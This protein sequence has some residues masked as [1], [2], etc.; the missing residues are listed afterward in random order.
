MLGVC[1]PELADLS[2]NLADIGLHV[3]AIVQN[4]VRFGPT[5]TEHRPGLGQIRPTSTECGKIWANIGLHSQKLSPRSLIEH[6]SAWLSPR[7]TAIRSS[8][9]TLER[10]T[11]KPTKPQAR[12]AKALGEQ[13]R[14]LR[15]G[16][17]NRL[18]IRL[19]GSHPAL[20]WLAEPAADA[21]SK[22]EVGSDG[23]TGIREDDGE[24][25][26]SRKSGAL[27]RSTVV[28]FESPAGRG[29]SSLGFEGESAAPVLIWAPVLISG[30][31]SFNVF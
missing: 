16:L 4:L 8:W 12:A 15:S 28:S 30:P 9:R 17:N 18:G 11:A 19:K 2:P 29:L 6:G 20:A 5:S 10:G 27:G 22:H 1:L 24:T 14:V 23:R 7:A 25:L 21:L 26:S 31:A 3:V 13:V